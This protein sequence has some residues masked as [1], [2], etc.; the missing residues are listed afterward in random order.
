MELEKVSVGKESG[1]VG[2][3]GGGKLVGFDGG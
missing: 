3:D 2:F 1:G